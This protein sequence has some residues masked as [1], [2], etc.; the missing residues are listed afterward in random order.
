MDCTDSNIDKDIFEKTFEQCA[1]GL[2]H[3]SPTGKFI[4]V[5]NKLSLFLGYDKEALTK[6]SIQ[7]IT[8]KSHMEKD[9]ALLRKLIRGDIDTYSLEKQYVH[10]KGHKVWGNLTVSL[11]RDSSGMPAYFISVVEDID[12]KKRIESEL[13]Q[14]EALFSKIVDSF[15]TRTFVWVADPT[16]SRL[17]YVNQGYQNIY[18][19]NEYELHVCPSRFLNYVHADDRIRVNELYAKKPLSSWDIEYR[20]RDI[21]GEIKYIHDRGTPLYDAN[22][23]QVLILGSADDI[24]SEKHHQEELLE[25][26]AKFE[27]LSK[28]DPLTGLLNRR[29]MFIQLRD[30]I[31]RMNRGQKS[32][33]LVYIDL[34]DFKQINDCYG[35]KAGDKALVAFSSI[36]LQSLRETDRFARLGGDEFV[37]LLYGS[38]SSDTDIF[39]RRLE[40]MPMSVEFENGE[41][42]TL[43]FSAGWATWDG[44]ISSAQDWVDA[45]DAAM[46]QRKRLRCNRI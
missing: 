41:F 6:K 29:E 30:E 14:V 44:T 8:P 43:T 15:A 11:V 10:A 42:T 12:D 32:S 46:Y 4:R 38:D 13:F 3:V 36:F 25:V 26:I 16:L 23:Q 2:A 1:V 27:H 39:L 40:S 9:L 45:A 18:G 17:H 35:H 33:T 34:N 28:T 22:K 37:L 31:E 20:I 7:Q 21:N 24:S 19:R 5:N